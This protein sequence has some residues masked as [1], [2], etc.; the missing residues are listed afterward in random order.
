MS[1]VSVLVPEVLALLNVTS[2]SGVLDCTVGN[3]GHS[4]AILD[5]IGNGTL[6]ALDQDRQALAR[7]KVRLEDKAKHAGAALHLVSENFRRLDKVLEKLGIDSVDAILMDLGWSSEQVEESGRG[8]SFQRKEPL[9][10]TLGEGTSESGETAQDI[11]NTATEEDLADLIYTYGEE[12]FSRRIAKGIVEAR[13]EGGITTTDRLVEIIE[14]SVP[15]FYQKRRIH[16]ATKTFQALRIAVNDELGVLRD[17]LPKALS[18]LKSGGRLVI[19]TFHS[20]EDRIVKHTF[21]EWVYEGKGSL[22]I[23]KPIVATADEIA[24]N[25]RARSAKVRGFIKA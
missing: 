8:F 2:G 1:H 17:A 25:K 16:A 3:G 11:V 4:E 9:L 23:K 6:V 21:R 14:Q 10:M 5:Q 13:K 19:I 24:R 7:S 18:S 22:L 20:L 15:K 12:Q